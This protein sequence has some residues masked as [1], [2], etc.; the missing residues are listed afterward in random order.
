VSLYLVVVYRDHLSRHD[1]QARQL[2]WREYVNNA[3][4]IK[5]FVTLAMLIS[6]GILAFA[7][8]RMYL[9]VELF[10]CLTV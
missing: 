3:L 10:H 5:P 4:K 2:A 9:G 8:W 6:V 1:N 7:L